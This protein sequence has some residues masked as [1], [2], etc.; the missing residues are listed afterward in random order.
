L[1]AGWQQHTADAS[2][3]SYVAPG[4]PLPIDLHAK[5]YTR[6]AFH[7][8]L[9]AMF[10]RATLDSHTFGCPVLLPDPIDVISHLIGHAL[11]SGS[12]WGGWGTELGDIAKIV[13]VFAPDPRR[14]AER[15]E[16]DGLDRAARFVLSRLALR[17]DAGRF[18]NAVVACLDRDVTGE[19]LVQ[20]AQRLHRLTHGDPRVGTVI[21]FLLD[22]SLSR[23]G[24][25]LVLRV[26]ERYCRDGAGVVDAAVGCD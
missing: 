13:E 11:K 6:G 26:C 23:G 8:G 7:V 3:A 25:A 5:L 15:L 10:E 16:T 2:E 21:G 14:C 1:A 20:T 19:A 12:T 9:Q 4:L 18:A 17:D 22:S 24:Y